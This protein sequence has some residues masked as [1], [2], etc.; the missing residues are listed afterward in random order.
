MA[1][2]PEKTEDSAEKAYAAAAAKAKT[3]APVKAARAA[4]GAPVI[5]KRAPKKAPVKKAAAKPAVKRAPTVMPAPIA[6]ALEPVAAVIQVPEPVAPVAEVPEPSAPV[7]EALE[8]EALVAEAPEPVATIAETPA[9]ALQDAA[10]PIAIT[11]PKPTI[12]ELKEKIMATAKTADF[13]KPVTEA[14]GEFQNKAK[15]AYEKSTE[16]LTEATEFAKGNVE[17][18]VE[19]GKIYAAGVQDLGK[20]YVEEAKSAY[21]TLTGDLKEIAAIKS[22]TELFQLQGK[23]L[24]RNFDA[25]VATSSKNTEAAM[26]LANDAFA[27]LTGRVNLAA[28]K[29][30]KVA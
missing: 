2:A 22:P 15:A 14:I 26:K 11:P 8:P 5:K 17:A 29:L 4:K 25:L 6:E 12:T 20:S 9:E 16:T 3:D 24:R 21:E 27:P 30:A 7:A 1:K 18:L 19:S 28:E 10:A 23:I 13:T